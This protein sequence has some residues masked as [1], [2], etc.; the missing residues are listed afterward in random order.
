MGTFGNLLS[1]LQGLIGGQPGAASA[2]F[3][4]ALADM[5]GYQGILD[6]FEQSGMGAQ[7]RSWLSANA[8][9]LP[10]TPDEIQAAL[11]D[12]RLQQLA[13]KFG[14]PLDQI[15]GLLAQHLP[16]AVDQAS[17]NG[18]LAPPGSPPAT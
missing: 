7:V 10:V 4:D 5:G 3:A 18:T 17:P 9:N 14:V 11:G 15:A 1:G 12:Q 2:L 13:A 16:T 6:R 8:S